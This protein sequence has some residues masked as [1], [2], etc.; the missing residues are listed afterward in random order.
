[1]P[2]PTGDR[3]VA[4]ACKLTT[5]LPWP[6]QSATSKPYATPDVRR[7]CMMTAI[8]DDNDPAFRRG[9]DAALAAARS[10]HEAKVKQAMV[11]STRTRFP[12]NLEREADLHRRCAELIV[13]L[14]PD[15]V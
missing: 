7:E 12:K 14:L 13:T 15:D 6:C 9:W 2:G 4:R 3:K 10:W 11:Q 8:K 1:M 5:I